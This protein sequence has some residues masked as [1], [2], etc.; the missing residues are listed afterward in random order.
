M[1]D[2]AMQQSSSPD[3][4]D[5]TNFPIHGYFAEDL[6]HIPGLPAH[7]ELI[8]GSLVLV[9]PQVRFHSLT[10]FLLELGL[11]RTLPAH[12]R[13]RR[14]MSVI[15]GPLQRPE[16]DL[17]VVDADAD[18][19]ITR[20]SSYAAVSVLLALEVVSVESA[21]RDRTRKPQLYAEAGIPHFWRVEESDGLPVVHTFKL[22]PVEK[23]YIATG[24]HHDRLTVGEPFEIDID[25]TEI[26]HL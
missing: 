11:R 5:W 13:V 20:Q 1:I 12:L 18:K 22:D 15:L 2:A 19:G 23:T 21:T 26:N 10:I 14:E 25:L 4:V 16:P 3:E 9:S 24:V 17:V 7:A 6:D 8:D